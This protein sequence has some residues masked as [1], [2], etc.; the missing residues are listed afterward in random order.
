V[1]ELQEILEWEVRKL[2]GRVPSQP[3]G[4][5]LD[6]AAEADVSVGLRRHERMFPH[7]A[8]RFV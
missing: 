1:D 8:A 2:A 4:S 6:R 7:L 5:A 3:E